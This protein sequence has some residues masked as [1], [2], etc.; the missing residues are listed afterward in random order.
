MSSQHG[1]TIEAHDPKTKGHRPPG[2][3]VLGLTWKI[4][5]AVAVLSG[6]QGCSGRTGSD[7]SR[8]EADPDPP[9]FQFVDDTEASKI[10]FTFRSGAEPSYAPIL[11]DLG[12]GCGL[13]DF[14]RDSRLDAFFPGGG[15]ITRGEEPQSYPH[16]LFQNQG[17]EGFRDVSNVSG[18]AESRHYSHGVAATDFDADGFPDLVV[19]GYG[20]LQLFHNQGDGTFHEQAQA[21]GLTDGQWSSSAA[22]GDVNGDGH[23]D[24][25]VCHYT[26]WSLTNDP[27]CQG[28]A[29]DR[30]ESC[31]PA[32]FKG[33]P[34]TLYLSTGMGRFE[35]VSG[36]AGLRQD[37]KGL[38]VVIADLD[39][40]G[41]AD[42]Y[43]AND[44]VANFLYR[45]EGGEPGSGPRFTEIGVESGVAL[46]D[47]GT[48]DG[49]MGCAVLDLNQDARPDLWVSNF[50]FETPGL[51]RNDGK[52]RF[53]HITRIAGLA[54]HSSS[55]VSFGT[56]AA[57]F[58]GDGDDDVMVANGNISR[59]PRNGHVLQPCQLFANL[60]N[61]KFHE[62]TSN[63]GACLSVPHLGRG[64]ALGDIDGD[65]DPDVVLSSKDERVRI[66]RN[67]LKS[68]IQWIT[69]HLTGIRSPRDGCGTAITQIRGGRRL[70]S[71]IYGG[72]SYLSAC[73]PEYCLP[74]SPTAA[75]LE[76][77]ILWPSGRVQRAHRISSKDP[78]SV[79]QGACTQS[80]DRLFFIEPWK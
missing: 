61:S 9:R 11:Q 51:Y 76:L 49:S 31:P 78:W 3:A 18:S 47:K 1:P 68:Q 77:E 20:G 8:P 54:R 41:D 6:C 19:T 4:V 2:F 63:A 71:W 34:D 33:L 17:A 14:D 74:E 65:G 48:A 30:P 55:Y 37:G 75:D 72:Q 42:I 60:G 36:A 25:Y 69:V 64:L 5:V 62:V 67:N 79:D 45:N 56:V 66:F 22:W 57:D 80:Q 24:L 16:G 59:Y 39:S 13:L 26:D 70:T 43:V 29:P 40:D 21:S 27:V 52:L 10:D 38:G 28:L 58:D 53:T 12:G 7:I 35:D 32:Q 23:P 15:H 73:S 50:E 46:S 44:T